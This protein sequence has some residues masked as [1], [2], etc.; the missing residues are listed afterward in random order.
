MSK[1]LFHFGARK[2]K[3]WPDTQR[4]ERLDEPSVII[5]DFSD[6]D[7]YHGRLRDRILQL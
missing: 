1:D 2:V 3:I 4:V 7:I 5:T 6:R